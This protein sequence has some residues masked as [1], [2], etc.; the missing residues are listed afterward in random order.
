LKTVGKVCGL[1][2]IDGSDLPGALGNSYKLYHLLTTTQ[3][4][5]S[6]GQIF[7]DYNYI[8]DSIVSSNQMYKSKNITK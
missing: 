4:F 3:Y 7:N 2:E 8:I 1:V 6:N 5:T